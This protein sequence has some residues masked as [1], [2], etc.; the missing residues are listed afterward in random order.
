MID[1]HVSR[2]EMPAKK[3]QHYPPFC[4]LSCISQ[5]VSL[6]LRDIGFKLHQLRT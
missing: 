3:R 5:S 4:Q 1:Q 2:Q 6:Y